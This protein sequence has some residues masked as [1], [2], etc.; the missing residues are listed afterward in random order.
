MITELSRDPAAEDTARAVLGAVGNLIT[1]H[2]SGPD[3]LCLGC[4]ELWARFVWHS[5]CPLVMWANEVIA[6]HSR[7]YLGADDFLGVRRG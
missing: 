7:A 4:E 1:L 2:R 5:G 6:A 3:G